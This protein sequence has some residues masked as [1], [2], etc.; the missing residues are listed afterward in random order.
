MPLKHSEATT[1]YFFWTCQKELTV[2]NCFLLQ[3]ISQLRFL[4]QGIV[5]IKQYIKV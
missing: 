2:I 3:L 1:K 4:S 5:S